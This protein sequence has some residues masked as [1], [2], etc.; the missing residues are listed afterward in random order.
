MKEIAF[1]N[2]PGGYWIE[3]FTPARLPNLLGKH[4]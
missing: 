2:D 1:I 3:I 4:L